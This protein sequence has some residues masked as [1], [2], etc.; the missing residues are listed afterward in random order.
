MNVSI[1]DF[2][3]AMELKNNGMELDVYDNAGKHLGDLV[4]TKT[5]LVWCPGKT[6]VK[7]GHAI[8]WAEFIDYMETQ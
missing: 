1:K 4:I 8:S 7:N 2:N 6:S 3:V 5:R